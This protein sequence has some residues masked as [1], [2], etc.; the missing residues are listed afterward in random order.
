MNRSDPS[1]EGKLPFA[2]GQKLHSGRSS[3][4]G[5][6]DGKERVSGWLQDVS[7]DFVAPLPSIRTQL[8]SRIWSDINIESGGDNYAQLARAK[9]DTSFIDPVFR[10]KQRLPNAQVGCFEQ[11]D[12]PAQDFLPI[13]QSSSL[14]RRHLLSPNQIPN[15][16][17]SNSPK[18]SSIDTLTASPQHPDSRSSPTAPILNKSIPYSHQKN[19]TFTPTQSDETFNYSRA[20][21]NTAR[22]IQ[23]MSIS[24]SE[25]ILTAQGKQV[26]SP[27]NDSA[28]EDESSTSQSIAS[29]P[30]SGYYQPVEIVDEVDLAR[31]R[32]RQK[33]HSVSPSEMSVYTDMS[34]YPYG[35]NRQSS[36]RLY[37]PFPRS[38]THGSGQIPRLR[39][40]EATAIKSRLVSHFEP[41]YSSYNFW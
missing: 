25:E 11:S 20:K 40:G 33:I 1:P 13:R 19:V 2:A 17:P 26:R 38:D 9:S 34:E 5:G 28:S 15:R 10:P 35:M 27:S 30:S 23:P 14:P 31:L 4:K 32:Q 3:R 18:P 29:P 36:K 41:R 16:S 8:P 39:P 7:E 37:Q 22:K 24:T 12:S 21:L 6:V